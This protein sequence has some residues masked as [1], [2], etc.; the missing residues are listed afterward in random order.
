[1]GRNMFGAVRGPWPDETWKV[2]WGDNPSYRTPLFVLTSPWP[3]ARR[4]HFVAEEIHAAL[5]RAA[6]AASSRDIR[7]GGG[8]ATVRQYLRTGLSAR[9]ISPF[10]RPLEH[11]LGSILNLGS[12]CAEH[13]HT[14]NATHSV[15]TKRR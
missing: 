3:A 11:L 5:E 7:L 4:F 9:C 15:L 1:M 10:P 8:V 12:E 14:P 6:D 2:W 13:V